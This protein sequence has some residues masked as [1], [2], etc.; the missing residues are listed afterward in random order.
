LPTT[1]RYR[2]QEWYRAIDGRWLLDAYAYDYFDLVRGGSIGYHW[3]PIRRLDPAGGSVY[4]VKCAAP[5]A[6]PRGDHFRGHMM[7]LFEARAVF[8]RID[9][10]GASISCHGL[11]P[12][13]DGTNG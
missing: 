5:G 12:L 8:T 9:A 7:T 4:H 10:L 2:Y 3:H 11:Y 1:A 13:G 6:D